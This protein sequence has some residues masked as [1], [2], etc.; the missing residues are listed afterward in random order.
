MIDSEHPTDEQI[1]AIV[2]AG[3]ARGWKK[4]LFFG[5]EAFQHRA[6]LE[7]LR[8]GFRPE[9]ITLECE[10]VTPKDKM[11]EH[12]RRTLGLP[13]PDAPP[14]RPPPPRD[15]SRVRDNGDD[16]RGPSE[17]AARPKAGDQPLS[18]QDLADLGLDEALAD[19]GLHD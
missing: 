9:E 5:S 2:A 7:A 8:Q 16:R 14:R 19:F 13:D 4:I 6:R 18:A 11:P 15:R 12:V 1:A 3:K 10:Q 17:K